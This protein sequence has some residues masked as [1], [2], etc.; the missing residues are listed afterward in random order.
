M[1]FKYIYVF[2]EKEKKKLKEKNVYENI[3]NVYDTHLILQQNINCLHY[4]IKTLEMIYITMT[5]H[6]EK[7]CMF[8]KLNLDI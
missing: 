7:M 4:E 1:K 5:H 8:T 6:V 2:V 3:K